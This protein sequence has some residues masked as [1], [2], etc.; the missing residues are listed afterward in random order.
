[1]P[2]IKTPKQPRSRYEYVTVVL[3]LDPRSDPKTP[4]LRVR[5]APTGYMTEQETT[6]AGRKLWYMLNRNVNASVSQALYASEKNWR[7]HVKKLWGAKKG[8]K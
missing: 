2:I 8:N 5:Y 6:L 1:M 7:K 4:R 3:K